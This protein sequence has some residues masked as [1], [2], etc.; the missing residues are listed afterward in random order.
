LIL[1]ARRARE[2]IMKR[3]SSHA[4][5]FA[6]GALYIASCISGCLVLAI[7]LDLSR[8]V[9]FTTLTAF[10]TATHLPRQASQSLP[11]KRLIGV[12]TCAAIVYAGMPICDLHFAYGRVVNLAR[13][14]ILCEPCAAGGRAFLNFYDRGLAPDLVRYIQTDP[15]LGN[16]SD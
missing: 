7:A 6:L 1:G 5:R 4:G 11:D 9:S 10:L 16:H 8:I 3:T 12:A 15:M 13:V 2:A 14:G